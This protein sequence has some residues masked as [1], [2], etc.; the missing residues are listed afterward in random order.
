MGLIVFVLVG[1]DF[2]LGVLSLVKSLFILLSF[3]QCFGDDGMEK[4]ETMKA[5]MV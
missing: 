1:D 2:L 3:T 4:Y 5:I